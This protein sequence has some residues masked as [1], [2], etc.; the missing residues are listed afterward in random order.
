MRLAIDL[1]VGVCGA[2]FALAMSAAAGARSPRPDDLGRVVPRIGQYVA[3]WGDRASLLVGVEDYQQS[4]TPAPLGQPPSRHLVSEFAIV[5]TT[6]ST[7]W[8]GLRD[9]GEVDGHP[10]ADRRDRLER[11][12][13]DGA[14]DGAR[15]RAIVEDS[16]RFNLGSIVRTVNV[17]TVALFFFTPA[18]LSRFAFK[19]AA[20]TWFEGVR[21]LEIGFREKSTPTLITRLGGGS[22]R[23]HGTLWVIPSDGTV[24]RTRLVVSGFTRPAS[25]A[26]V[27]VQYRR[28]PRLDLWLPAQ[29]TERYEATVRNPQSRLLEQARASATATYSRFRRFE[30]SARIAPR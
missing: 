4:Y 21:V 7:G 23:S 25:I 11:L 22:V 19:R 9:V 15:A 27:D 20:E 12:F 26:E 8:V 10:V 29:M 3:S 16:A 14:P 18:N 2:A 30:T 17:P 13:L 5:R 6:D 1:R 24:V 28:D